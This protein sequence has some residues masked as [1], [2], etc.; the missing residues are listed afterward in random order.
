MSH[1]RGEGRL[2]LAWAGTIQVNTVG[3]QFHGTTGHSDQKWEALAPFV[4]RQCAWGPHSSHNSQALC[5]G[6]V[7]PNKF[8]DGSPK[9]CLD[10]AGFDQRRWLEDSLYYS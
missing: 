5:Y 10:R 6:S 2:N 3:R 7:N 1:M 8:I 9:L 4:L